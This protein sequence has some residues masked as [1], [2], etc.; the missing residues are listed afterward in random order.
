MTLIRWD[1][2]RN[3]ATLQDRINRMFD[4]AF[5][6]SKDIDDEVS[7]ASWKPTVDIYDTDDAIVLKVELPGVDK[8][9][10]SVDVKDNVLT[11]KGERSVDKE[12]KEK[13]YYRRER[14]FGSFHRSFTLPTTVNPEDIKA[15]YK[16][17]I[18][19]IE[20]PKPEEKKPK[21][22]TIDVK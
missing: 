12:I 4:E 21:Q 18:L 16:D 19:T 9:K 13:N 7:L 22:I 5:L 17:G 3:V 20:V 2:F 1:P 11:L 15:T 8:E 14:S 6:R 10:V